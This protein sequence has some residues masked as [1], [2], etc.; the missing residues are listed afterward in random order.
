MLLD[1][2]G[3]LISD[4]ENHHIYRVD[5]AGAVR[6]WADDP[7]LGGTLVSLN[8]MDFTADKSLS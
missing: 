5:S 6:V 1:G 4:R 2:D 8:S 3:A 7:L